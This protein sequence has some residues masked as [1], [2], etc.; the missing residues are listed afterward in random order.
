MKFDGLEPRHYEDIKEILA[1]ERGSKSYGTFEK[2]VPH[3]VDYDESNMALLYSDIHLQRRLI[4][5][6]LGPELPRMKQLGVA[7]KVTIYGNKSGSVLV[8]SREKSYCLTHAMSPGF[9]QYSP[10][11]SFCIS[12]EI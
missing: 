2:Q 3:Q 1:P 11:L 7:L 10:S 9:I 8:R 6:G 5:K 4:T 12:W